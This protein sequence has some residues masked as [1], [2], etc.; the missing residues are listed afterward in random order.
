MAEPCKKYSSEQISRFVD[1][2]LS[3]ETLKAIEDHQKTCTQC[4]DLIVSYQAFGKQFSDHADQ[5][6]TAI[7][8]EKIKAGLESKRTARPGLFKGWTRQNIYLKLASIVAIV[9]ISLAV[10]Q[11]IPGTRLRPAGPEALIEPSAIVKS[12]DTDFSSVM[13]IETQKQKHTIIWYSEDP[14]TN[15]GV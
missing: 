10:F 5:K 8:P 9:G 3:N 11:S 1:R 12:L 15:E 7:D 14:I 13:I 6:I 2:E 4:R